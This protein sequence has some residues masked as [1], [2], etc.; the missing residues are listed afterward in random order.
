[1]VATLIDLMFLV[2]IGKKTGKINKMFLNGSK[3]LRRR[4][5][6]V[7]KHSDGHWVPTDVWP[8]KPH[9]EGTLNQDT[10]DETGQCD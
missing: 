2:K 6:M 3:T 1:M 10:N 7:T 8:K 5:E 9:K 4:E